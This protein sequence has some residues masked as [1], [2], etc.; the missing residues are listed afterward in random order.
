MNPQNNVS[1]V[2]TASGPEKPGNRKMT[3]GIISIVCFVLGCGLYACVLIKSKNVV[4]SVIASGLASEAAPWCCNLYLASIVATCALWVVGP[5]FGI[6]GLVRRERP[7]LP[8]VLGLVSG[9]L[10]TAL[11]FLNFL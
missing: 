4:G 10:M 7:R 5:G 9:A 11:A 8:A 1:P 3:C 2:V 6:A